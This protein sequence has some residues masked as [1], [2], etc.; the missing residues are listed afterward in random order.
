[1][2]FQRPSHASLG[3]GTLI[4]KRTGFT[5]GHAAGIF[6]G[7]ALFLIF[8]SGQYLSCWTGIGITGRI[9]GEGISPKD[10]SANGSLLLN[11]DHIGHMTADTSL[12]AFAE[13]VGRSVLRICDNRLDLLAGMLFML[14]DQIH[15]GRILFNVSLTL[16]R[17]KKAVRM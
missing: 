7:L 9:I 5:C 16:S 6:V 15:Q 17:G 12:M 8:T 2:T 4:S 3:T 13:I 14:I 11:V 1:M 10:L